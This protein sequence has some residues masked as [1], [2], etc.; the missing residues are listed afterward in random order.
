MSLFDVDINVPSASETTFMY[1]PMFFSDV[2]NTARRD[3]GV[4]TAIR[5]ASAKT[6]ITF[7][8]QPWDVSAGLVTLVSKLYSL[9]LF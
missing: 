7:A 3:T 5:L 1:K 6:I 2:K 9:S 8:T 4:K